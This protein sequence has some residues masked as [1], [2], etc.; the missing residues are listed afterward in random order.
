MKKLEKFKQLNKK[1]KSKNKKK[2][3]FILPGPGINR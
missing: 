3:E 2:K 1:K